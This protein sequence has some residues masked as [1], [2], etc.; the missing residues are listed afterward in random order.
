[1][2]IINAFSGTWLFHLVGDA[3][4]QLPLFEGLQSIGWL[5]FEDLQ[6]GDIRIRVPTALLARQQY[7]S[8]IATILTNRPQISSPAAERPRPSVRSPQ[9]AGLAAL[10]SG[11]ARRPPS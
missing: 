8:E 11:S 5:N 3:D 4:G 2:E 7:I 6:P 9:D 1:M 10:S